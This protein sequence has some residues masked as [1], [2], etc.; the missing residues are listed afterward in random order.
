MLAISEALAVRSLPQVLVLHLGENELVNCSVSW[1]LM[2]LAEDIIRVQNLLPRIR[3]VWTDMLSRH[4][5]HRPHD[6]KVFDALRC[7]LR[8]HFCSILLSRWGP[9][10]DRVVGLP[11]AN[12]IWLVAGQPR[13]RGADQVSTNMA[14]KG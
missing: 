10:T 9:G 11:P 3:L 7:T 5:W 8:G 6:L 12:G 2:R 4:V 14:S 13:T 1:F